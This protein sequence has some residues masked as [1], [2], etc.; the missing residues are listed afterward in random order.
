MSEP[1][2]ITEEYPEGVDHIVVEKVRSFGEMV[3][4]EFYVSLESAAE[5]IVRRYSDVHSE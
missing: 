3:R 4:D 2:V 5:S 1:Y